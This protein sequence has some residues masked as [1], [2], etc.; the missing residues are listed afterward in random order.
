MHSFFFSKIFCQMLAGYLW[1][2]SHGVFLLES[3]KYCSCL[4]LGS[5]RICLWAAGHHLQLDTYW[6]RI[7]CFSLEWLHSATLS[8]PCF[9]VMQF[10]IQI[11]LWHLKK[12]IH[13]CEPIKGDETPEHVINAHQLSDMQPYIPSLSR[14]L[15][16]TCCAACLALE[17]KDCPPSLWCSFQGM[18]STWLPLA[19]NDRSIYGCATL[20]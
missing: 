12:L 8:C 10:W 7:Y 15:L 2:T 3:H 16:T 9:W 13:F 14:F 6:C 18:F 17:V 5:C 11:C 4:S 19:I 20:G 1:P